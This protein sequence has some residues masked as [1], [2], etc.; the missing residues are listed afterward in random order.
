MNDF[1]KLAG[2]GEVHSSER[3]RQTSAC[4]SFRSYVD[5]EYLRIYVQ[6][7]ESSIYKHTVEL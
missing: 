4:G 6:V 7:Y 2:G 5:V 3:A 1:S